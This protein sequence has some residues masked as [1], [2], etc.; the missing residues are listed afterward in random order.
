MSFSVQRDRQLIRDLLQEIEQYRA[1]NHKE[2][3]ER[4]KSEQQRVH[5]ATHKLS[6]AKLD[7]EGQTVGKM[8]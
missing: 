2:K 4:D 1:R 8:C 6:G 5:E 7:E 3:E